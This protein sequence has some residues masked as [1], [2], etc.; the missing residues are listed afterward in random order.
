MGLASLPA[1]PGDRRPPG[2]AAAGA[3]GTLGLGVWLLIVWDLVLDPAMAHEDLAVRFWEWS[4]T[5][6]YYGMPIQNYVGWAATGAPLHG[7]SRGLWGEDVDLSR[8]DVWIP[9][10]V[11]VANTVF[12]M[13]LSASVDLYV[14]IVL[15]ADPRP[16]PRPFGLP[17]GPAGSDLTGSGRPTAPVIREGTPPL[18]STALAEWANMPIS[19]TPH[20]V[21]EPPHRFISGVSSAISSSR[22]KDWSTSRRLWTGDVGPRI[23]TI[24]GMVRSSPPFSTGRSISWSGSTGATGPVAADGGSSA[25]PP[26]PDGLP[27]GWIPGR[28]GQAAP[29]RSPIPTLRATETVALLRSGRTRDR[30]SGGIPDDRPAW[31]AQAGPDQF[32]PFRPGFLQLVEQAQRAGSRQ[33]SDH[34]GRVRVRAAG[35]QGE[36]V[37]CR[38][39]VRRSAQLVAGR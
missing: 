18:S 36:A 24:F 31:D 16:G 33:R 25:G 13:A 11:Y 3:A 19:P 32:L 1:G 20:Y 12:A 34:P 6:P 14:P 30:L 9:L 10:V 38:C 29:R 37:A 21:W 15:S 22:W 5:G 8:T 2:L 35:S 28:S 23:S 26:L 4:E 7:F 39:A 17:R 27:D